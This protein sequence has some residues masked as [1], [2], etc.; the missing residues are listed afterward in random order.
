MKILLP[1]SFGAISPARRKRTDDHRFLADRNLADLAEARRRPA[2][3]DGGPA[4]DAGAAVAVQRVPGRR[5]RHADQREL[6]DSTVADDRFEPGRAATLVASDAKDDAP[7]VEARSN[8]S[9]RWLGTRGST[10]RRACNRCAARTRRRCRAS[11]PR[12]AR[13]RAD[14][15]APED[16]TATCVDCYGALSF[17][18]G[19]ARGE[20]GRRAAPE[21]RRGRNAG[22]VAGRADV[23]RA[24]RP[25]R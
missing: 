25:Q 2:G 7:P 8:S 11:A 16:P 12:C 13:L 5:R 22:R 20:A 3:D 1:K 17:R 15:T 19:G 6:H 4:V 18:S 24:R 10:E 21:P 14:L 9:R 23:P